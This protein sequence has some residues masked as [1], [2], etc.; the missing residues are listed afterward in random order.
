MNEA[1]ILYGSTEHGNPLFSSDLLWRTKFRVPDPV[2]FVEY[3]GE[4]FIIVSALEYERAKHEAR[5]AGVVL[6]DALSA[7]AESGAPARVLLQFL[8]ELRV[9]RI[10]VPSTFP[11]SLAKELESSI[12]LRVASP[13][14]FPERSMKSEWELREIEATECAVESAMQ[15]LRSVLKDSTIRERT[16]L[17]RGRKLTSEYLRRM[18]E[19]ELWQ[20]GYAT[21]GTI[22]SCGTDAAKPH[23]IGS[24]PLEPRVPIIVDVFPYSRSSYYYADCTRTFFKGEPEEPFK[25]MYETVRG[26]Q[27]QALAD[28]R[29]GADAPE[30]YAAAVRYF[31]ERGYASPSPEQGVCGF[32]HGLGHGVGLEIHELP[33]LGAGG[34][35]LREGNVITIE[36]GLYYP[37]PLGDIPA[38]GIR[39]EDLVAVTDSGCRNLTTL[40]K[41]LEWAIVP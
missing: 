19:L 16:V 14:L 28:I 40:P 10:A 37:K 9:M 7:R 27:E 3:G 4:A 1:I 6:Q 30:L 24:G 17:Y 38:G 25:R 29:L 26:A 20:K 21:S 11:V 36:P 22:I 31:S 33:S 13:P 34:G 39:I 2:F 12:E 41:S 23:A 32:I 35:A 18:V 5:G 15:K 8:S